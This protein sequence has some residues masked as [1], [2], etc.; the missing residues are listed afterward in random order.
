[1]HPTG[2]RVQ[3]EQCSFSV[4]MTSEQD[5]PVGVSKVVEGTPYCS[6]CNVPMKPIASVDTTP[7][8]SAGISAAMTLEQVATKC[9][10]IAHEAKDLADELAEAKE[11]HSQAKK[12]YDAKLVSL[13]LAVERMGRVQ[14]GEQ[15]EP[16]KPLLDIAEQA[17][18]RCEFVN[19]LGVQCVG[20]MD[21]GG[22]HGNGDVSW[23]TPSLA[24]EYGATLAALAYERLRVRLATLHVVVELADIEAWT[25]EQYDAVVRYT[26]QLE[27][28]LPIDDSERPP[29][30]SIDVPAHITALHA[31]LSRQGLIIGLGTICAWTPEEREQAATWAAAE[32][33]SPDSAERPAHVPGPP[34]GQPRAPRR[35]RKR[36]P[37]ADPVHD[38]TLADA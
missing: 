33:E 7:R 5:C 30:L 4:V 8:P 31:S 15:I 10:E 11:A 1:M 28:G 17:P 20:E 25:L 16:D 29:F 36:V 35:G 3:C 32:A 2:V 23:E 26:E 27:S 24:A 21:H 19:G 14:G 34:A 18:G 38:E 37:V 12:S 22:P 9:V 6:N 13:Q